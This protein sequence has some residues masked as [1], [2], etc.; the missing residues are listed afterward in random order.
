[1]PLRCSP[2]VREI[3]NHDGAVLLD[4]HHGTCVSLTPVAMFIW[5]KLKENCDLNQVTEAVAATFHEASRQQIQDDVSAFVGDL[6]RQGLL[7]REGLASKTPFCDRL[8]IAWHRFTTK[9]KAASKFPRFLTLKAFLGLFAFDLFGLGRSFIRIHDLVQSWRIAPVSRPMV[10]VEAVCTAV[11]HACVWYP[12][13]VLCL[14]RSVITTCLL[15]HCGVP[16]QMVMGAQKFPFRAH[17]W[18]EV[19]K[20]PINE[21]RNVQ[22]YLVWERC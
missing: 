4:I 5:R 15:R 16:A 6:Q 19:D 22:G 13:R 2:A 11:N 8:L 20:H 17:A 10:T 7:L 18:T 3:E 9:R 12:K 1:M 14:Q 21:I